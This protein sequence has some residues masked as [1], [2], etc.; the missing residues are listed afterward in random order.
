MSTPRL[1]QAAT[2]TGVEKIELLDIEHAQPANLPEEVTK[3][4]SRFS[5]T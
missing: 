1:I 4:P 3:G 2:L 5:F